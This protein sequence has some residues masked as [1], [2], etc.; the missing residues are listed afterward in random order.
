[1][2]LAVAMLGACG[3]EEPGT[4]SIR[5]GWDTRPADATE[6]WATI[7]VRERPVLDAPGRT[8]AAVENVRFVVGEGLTLTELNVPN[9]SDRQVVIELRGSPLSEQRVRYYGLSERFSLMAGE[10]QVIPVALVLSAPAT[11]ANNTL[12]VRRA[13]GSG[14]SWGPDD[15]DNVDIHLTTRA[16]V[17]IELANNASFTDATSISVS[18]PACAPDPDGGQICIQTGWDLTRTTGSTSEEL[19]TVY[20]RF[21]DANGYGSPIVR[22]TVGIDATAPRVLSAAVSARW[23]VPGH[24]GLLISATVNE[25]VQPPTLIVTPP[26]GL[27]EVAVEEDGRVFIWQLDVAANAVGSY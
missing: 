24:R 12:E 11:E 27:T 2:F 7:E 5:F 26:V 18:A 19:F 22:Q 9:G 21:V 3:S 1:M 25:D 14:A 4:V 20:A 23:V 17:V 8:L 10:T 15:I 16:A 13:G 6:L